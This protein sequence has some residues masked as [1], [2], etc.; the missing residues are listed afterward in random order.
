[1]LPICWCIT[2]N[3]FVLLPDL[4]T[5]LQYLAV[6][7]KW[8]Y[9]SITNVAELLKHVETRGSNHPKEQQMCKPSPSFLK[10]C[11]MNHSFHHDQLI[12]NFGPKGSHKAVHVLLRFFHRFSMPR[13]VAIRSQA[14]SGKTQA[15]F[16][17][18][19]L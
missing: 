7:S 14:T 13:D 10:L 4:S 1:M 2:W 8:F 12:T 19:D 15:T 3:H 18:V 17:V 11:R 5:R 16:Q 6:N 9:G